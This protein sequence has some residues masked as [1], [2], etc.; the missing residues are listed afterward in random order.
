MRQRSGPGGE[1]AVRLRDP[2]ER[3]WWWVGDRGRLTRR[4]SR[5]FTYPPNVDYVRVAEEV[6]QRARRFGFVAE[7]APVRGR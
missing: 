5:A 3:R 1:V 6:A 4:R 7:V 2:R